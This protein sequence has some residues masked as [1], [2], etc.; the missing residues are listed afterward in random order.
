MFGA[1]I[2]HSDLDE[3]WTEAWLDV[4]EAMVDGGLRSL[5]LHAANMKTA[6]VH[7]ISQVSIWN[8]TTLSCRETSHLFSCAFAFSLLLFLLHAC[9]VIRHASIPSQILRS[10]AASHHPALINPAGGQKAYVLDDLVLHNDSVSL[11]LPTI[12]GI[13]M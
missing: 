6:I 4:L 13:P 8:I 3:F 12:L 10:R 9:G 1:T 5:T 11:C 7:G 2:D